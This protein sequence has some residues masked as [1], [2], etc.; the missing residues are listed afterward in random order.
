MLT[1]VW[2]LCIAKVKAVLSKK[3]KKAAEHRFEK[4]KPLTI[5]IN[6][7]D[8]LNAHDNGASLDKA[9]KNLRVSTSR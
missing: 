9:I 4:A 2:S 3:N 5:T 7:E 6:W 8:V 1:Q